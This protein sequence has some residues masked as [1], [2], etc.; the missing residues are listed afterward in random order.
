[1]LLEVWFLTT[2]HLVGRNVLICITNTVIFIIFTVT[3]TIII[4]IT[5]LLLTKM[6]KY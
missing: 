3:I 4:I 1:M 2:L 6:R 5:T